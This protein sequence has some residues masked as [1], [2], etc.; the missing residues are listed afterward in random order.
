M[1]CP[2][3]LIGTH[4]DKLL[5]LSSSLAPTSLNTVSPPLVTAVVA[6][7]RALS[8]RFG[9]ELMFTSTGA[10]RQHR[11][12]GTS[13]TLSNIH[14]DVNKGQ[15]GLVQFRNRLTTHVTSQG[16]RGFSNELTQVRLTITRLQQDL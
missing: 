10:S 9:C 8:L 12:G 15:V 5:A 14:G 6:Y 2:V 11:S 3:L 1:P 4:Y 16:M 7:L 13:N